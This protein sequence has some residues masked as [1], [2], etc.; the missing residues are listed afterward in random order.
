[1]STYILSVLYKEEIEQYTA[2]EIKKQIQS[3]YPNY[4]VEYT[5]WNFPERE[6]KELDFDIQDITF[7]KEKIYDEIDTLIRAMLII[8]EELTIECDIIGGHNDTENWIVRYEEDK[9]N[10]YKQF[11]LFGT[12]NPIAKSRPYCVIDNVT[13]YQNFEFDSMGVMF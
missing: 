10:Y 12:R 9:Q 5:F 6:Y 1:M 3:L 4:T 13:I 11:G 7:N 2:N 8:F